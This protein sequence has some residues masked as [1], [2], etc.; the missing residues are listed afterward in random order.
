[1]KRPLNETDREAGRS[2]AGRSKPRIV[3]SWGAQVLPESTKAAGAVECAGLSR[4]LEW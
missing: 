3:V 1:M 2:A 4:V